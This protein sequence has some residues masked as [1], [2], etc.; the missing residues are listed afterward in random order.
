[1]IERRLRL[2][3]IV[4][5]VVGIYGCVRVGFL[6]VIGTGKVDLFVV[7]IVVELI[8]AVC[9]VVVAGFLARIRLLFMITR[10]KGGIW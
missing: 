7:E 4:K 10:K 3:V 5:L 6:A 9:A 1:M 2:G 8:A